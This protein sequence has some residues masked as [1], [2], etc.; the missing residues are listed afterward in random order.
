MSA[1]AASSRAP[2]L[3]VRL[4]EPAMV[5]ILLLNA[6]VV[7]GVVV[8]LARHQ[9]AWTRA[10]QLPQQAGSMPPPPANQGY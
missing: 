6:A 4:L 1:K 7:V 10:P 5:L 9:D 2:A 8:A 3:A